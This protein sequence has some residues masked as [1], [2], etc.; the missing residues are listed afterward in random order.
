MKIEHL[1]PHG[2]INIYLLLTDKKTSMF[3]WLKFY[4]SPKI[5]RFKKTPYN[6]SLVLISIIHRYRERGCCN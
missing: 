2:K 4:C 6:E 1:I 3:S 5:L